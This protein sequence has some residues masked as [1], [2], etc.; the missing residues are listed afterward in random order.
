MFKC[1]ASVKIDSCLVAIDPEAVQGC[2]FSQDER[3]PDIRQ[4]AH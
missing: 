3:L 4:E 2:N 1:A